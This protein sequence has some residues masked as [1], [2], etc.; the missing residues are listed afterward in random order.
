MGQHLLTVLK[1][2][3]SVLR[4]ENEM[5]FL[6]KEI[7]RWSSERSRVIAVVSAIGKTTDRLMNQAVG[8]WREL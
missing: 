4:T 6:V 7:R 8:V 3:S 1:F 5:G 2:G